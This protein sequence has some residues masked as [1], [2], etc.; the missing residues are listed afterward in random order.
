MRTTDEPPPDPEAQMR[1]RLRRHN[2]ALAE[3]AATKAEMVSALLH[4]LRTPLTA[5]LGMLEMLPERTGD[6]LLDEALPLIARNL[7]RIE[8]TTA[9]IATISGI[10]SGTIP[11]ARTEFDLPALLTEVAGAACHAVPPAGPVLGDRDRL[12]QVF[13]RLLSAVRALDGGAEATAERVED[14]WRVSYPLPDEQASD[15][16]FT[17]AGTGGN[18]MALMLARAVIGRHGGSVGVHSAGGTAYLRVVLPV[19]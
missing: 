10:E 3:L 6:P 19:A 2:R 11:L 7:R 15:R 14:H 13:D 16:L 12:R 18:A 5:A 17:S 1:H 8:R 9:E 4:E